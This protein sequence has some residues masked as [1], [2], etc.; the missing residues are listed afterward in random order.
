MSWKTEEKNYLF[1]YCKIKKKIEEKIEK[2]RDN[3]YL[4]I[5]N[6]EYNNVLKASQELDELIVQYMNQY[7]N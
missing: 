2:L 4:I 6:E 1:D 3:L 7:S 5:E